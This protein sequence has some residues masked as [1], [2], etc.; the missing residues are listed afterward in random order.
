[1]AG[2]GTFD[3]AAQGRQAKAQSGAAGGHVQVVRCSGTDGRTAFSEAVFSFWNGLCGCHDS[4]K[5]GNNTKV[6]PVGLRETPF[7]V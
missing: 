6:R 2:R 5:L 4:D 3:A 7:G 1:M